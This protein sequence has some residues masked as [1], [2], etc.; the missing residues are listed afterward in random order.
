MTTYQP[1]RNESVWAILVEECGASEEM[2]DEFLHHA[3][4]QDRLEFRFQGA[5]GFG[6]KVYL[7][8]ARV[9]CYREDETPAR[10]AMIAAANERLAEVVADV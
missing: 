2:R 1:D 5:L 6:G 4:R 9:S 10:L 8:E 3:Q 7:P